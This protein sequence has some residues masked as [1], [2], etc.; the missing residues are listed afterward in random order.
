MHLQQYKDIWYGLSELVDNAPQLW[1]IS[2]EEDLFSPTSFVQYYN[3]DKYRIDE[4]IELYKIDKQTR[5]N[6]ICECF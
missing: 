4:A 5:E 1:F 3:S 6:L 2:D